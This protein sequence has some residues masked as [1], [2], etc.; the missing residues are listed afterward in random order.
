MNN[1]YIFIAVIA[2][3]VNLLLSV[4]VPC[5]VKKTDQPIVSQVRQMFNQNREMLLA[6][7]VLVAVIVFIAL[8][9]A[10]IARSELPEGL[11]NLASLRF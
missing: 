7:S 5:A 2:G 1:E 6:S 9:V 8:S 3:L 4:L 10:P 11:V